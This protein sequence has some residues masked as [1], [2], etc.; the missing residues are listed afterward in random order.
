M[1]E[2]IKTY[3]ID[4]T[5]CPCCGIMPC[6]WCY[7]CDVAKSPKSA[8]VTFSGFTGA[9]TAMNRSFTVEVGA[10]CDPNHSCILEAT[11][12]GIEPCAAW[13][14]YGLWR[15]IRLEIY[16][17]TKFR[18]TATSPADSDPCYATNIFGGGY[19]IGL[20]YFNTTGNF[21]A[22]EC[23]ADGTEYTLNWDTAAGTEIFCAGVG[24]DLADVTG[25]TATVQILETY[26]IP[27]TLTLSFSGPCAAALGTVTL[28][29]DSGSST[30]LGSGNCS[31]DYVFDPC[32]GGTGLT[33]SGD[34]TITFSAFAYDDY[35]PISGDGTMT[36]VGSS[37]CS[38][39][40]AAT[41]TYLI[42]A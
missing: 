33:A 21:S 13:T 17:T 9:F 25:T 24:T 36:A 8:L 7:L 1:V 31:I 41:T 39:G 6:T 29:Y 42:S 38:A 26:S 5:G 30:Y 15:R 27:G 32:E 14:P 10:T 35:F 18:L 37:C 20:L 19:A 23:G 3:N 11:W 22:N 4:V 2:V 12:A 28:T 34:G 40:D 16:S